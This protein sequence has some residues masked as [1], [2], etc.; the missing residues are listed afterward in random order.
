MDVTEP[1]IGEYVSIQ[2][3]LTDLPAV[4]MFLYFDKSVFY[5]IIL[6]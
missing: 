4:E 1:Y 3:M 6:L 2:V 5:I